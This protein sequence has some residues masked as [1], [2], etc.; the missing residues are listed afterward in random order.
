MLLIDCSF[1]FSLLSRTLIMTG[2]YAALL[3]NLHSLGSV[4]AIRAF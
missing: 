2:D 1:K 4:P 3:R